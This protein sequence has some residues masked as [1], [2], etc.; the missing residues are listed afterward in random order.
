MVLK[1]SSIKIYKVRLPKENSLELNQKKSGELMSVTFIMSSFLF[2]MVG[3]TIDRYGCRVYLLLFSSA[4]ILISFI[5]LAFFY[6]LFPLVILGI[7]YSLFG[8]IVWPTVSYLIRKENL[9]SKIFTIIVLIIVL[10]LY[11]AIC[12][13]F[14]LI[15]F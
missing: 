6:P 1:Y 9:V 10:V 11:F 4:L 13:L 2:P 12:M 7:A 8:G 3:M 14:F 15:F 5:L